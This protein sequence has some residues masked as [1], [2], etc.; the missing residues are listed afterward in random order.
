MKAALFTGP[1]EIVVRE[2]PD[3][4]LPSDGLIL[5]VMAC[6]VCGSDLRRW[7]QGPIPGAGEQIP[8]HEVSGVV[9]AVGEALRG[10]YR[11]GDRLA[12]A[13][14]VRCG[15][16]YYC[17][18]GWYNLCDDLRIVG[19]TPGYAGG[20]AERMVITGEILQNGIVHPLPDGLSFVEGALAEPLSSVLAAHQMAQTSL[21]DRVVIIGAGPIGCLHIAVAKRRG[22]RVL[23][24]QRSAPRRALAARFGP[25]VIIDPTDQDLVEAVLA[26]TDGLGADIAICANPVAATQEQAVRLVRKRGQVILFGGLP[27]TNPMTT[28]DGNRIHYGEIRLFGVFSYHPSMHELALQMMGEGIVAADQIV[29]HTFSL[30]ETPQ[31]F[32]T[33]AHGEGLK[34][35]VKPSAA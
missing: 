17:R 16:C 7:R 30:E 15:R 13:P 11:E 9:V 3:P 10:R 1:E 6:G 23:V 26:W 33:A 35:M 4:P 21:G 32:R 25:D 29:T 8:G 2:V 19:I 18:R 24:A 22:A 34:V 31:A 14:D 27:R 5:Q 20:F 28:L 12:L